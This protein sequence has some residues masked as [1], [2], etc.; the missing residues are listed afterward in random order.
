MAETLMLL[1]NPRFGKRRRRNPAG[2]DEFGNPIFIS[3]YNPRRRRR[4]T[5]A[6]TRALAMPSTWREWT[7]GVDL[8][9]A[10]SAAGGLTAAIS[11]P[12]VFVKDTGTMVNKFWKL[13]VSLGCALGAGALGKAMISPSAG[14]A[15]A[16]G[17]IA[18]T[19]AQAL[20]MFIPNFPSI[21]QR[22]MLG[23]RRIGE[24]VPVS[25]SSTR[26]GENVGII[27]P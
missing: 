19:T 22:K 18:G 24:T 16:I 7:Q 13:T 10:A 21:G 15:A 25:Y 12:G 27:I 11:L 23:T 2:F 9:D 4:N 8:M 20:A 26:E 3:G 5:M 17:G 14:K 1:E 6:R